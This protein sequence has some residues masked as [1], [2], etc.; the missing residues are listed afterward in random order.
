VGQGNADCT[1]QQQRCADV[2]D[3]KKSATAEDD[4][5]VNED[6]FEVSAT[7]SRLDPGAESEQ[8][9]HAPFC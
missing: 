1:K 3:V 2:E 5:A 4:A 6:M 9:S 7:P 8:W